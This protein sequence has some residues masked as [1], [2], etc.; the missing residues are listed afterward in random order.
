MELGSRAQATMGENLCIPSA[1]RALGFAT[2]VIDRAEFGRVR[3]NAG[4][5][6]YPGYC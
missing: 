2:E 6:L 1:Q 4:S 5:G 3:G